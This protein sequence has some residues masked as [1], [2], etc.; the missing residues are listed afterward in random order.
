MLTALGL[1][2]RLRVFLALAVSAGVCFAVEY[3]TGAT[4]AVLSDADPAVTAKGKRVVVVGG[5]DTG[6]DCVGTALRQGCASVVQLEMRPEPPLSRPAGDPWPLWPRTLRTDYGQQEAMFRQ[7]ADP[8]VYCTTVRRVLKS[9]A[10]EIKGIETV[11]VWR[12]ESGRMA[13]VPGTEKELPCEL[14]LIAAGFL[15]CETE[16]ARLFRAETDARGNLSGAGGSHMLRDGLFSA[17][18]MRTGQSLV[19]RALADGR[20][21]AKEVHAY[22]S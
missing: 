10:G 11:R 22:L 16:T 4:K 6:N 18:D 19:V 8:R 14:L 20:A 1:R 15:G 2:L 21:G 9:G 13:Q 12:D 3:L 17:G 7:G 5:G